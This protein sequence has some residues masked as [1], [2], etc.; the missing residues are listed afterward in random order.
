MMRSSAVS[1]DLHGWL[2]DTVGLR[3]S[4][5]AY[6]AN[7]IDVAKFDAA[8]IRHEPRHL[9]S[10]FAPDGAVVVV[11]VA[12]L[13][14]VKD[15]ACLLSA[16]KLMREMAGFGRANVHLVIAGDGPRRA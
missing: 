16:F 3:E 15:Q 9:L 13:D 2:V 10:D 12:R 6:S 7:G 5:V 14:E 8:R 4:R 1:R 11:N